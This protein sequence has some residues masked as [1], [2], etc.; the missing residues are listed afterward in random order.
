M[1]IPTTAGAEGYALD[2]FD[3]E[4]NVFQPGL[5]GYLWLPT[6]ASDNWVGDGTGRGL[7]LALTRGRG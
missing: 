3:L 4:D 2:R 7:L 5:G 6:G 1:I